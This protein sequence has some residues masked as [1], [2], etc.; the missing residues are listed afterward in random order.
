MRFPAAWYQIE[1]TLRER[2][3]ALR[4][5]QAR[6]LAT[7]L[8]GALSGGSACQSAV[9]AEWRAEGYGEA[10]ARQ[11][12]REALWD[13]AHKAAPCATEIEVDGC[14]APLLAWVLDWWT[15]GRRLPLAVDATNLC[16]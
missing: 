1:R 16:G 4:P 5:A 12:L 3:P 2:L 6:G 7:W 15:D 8:Y 14:F 9:I 10:A 13:G 11:R